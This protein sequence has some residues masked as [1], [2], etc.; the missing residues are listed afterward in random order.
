MMVGLDLFEDSGDTRVF[1]D[2]LASD[3]RLACCIL[4][5]ALVP[6]NRLEEHLLGDEAMVRIIG[7]S[8][9]HWTRAECLDYY[10]QTYRPGLTRRIEAS[11]GTGGSRPSGG[12]GDEKD[13]HY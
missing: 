10:V 8:H 12:P 7:L 11:R 1:R 4:C 13:S 2:P 6:T 5:G 3:S 9:P